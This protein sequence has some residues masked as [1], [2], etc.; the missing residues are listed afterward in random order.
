MGMSPLRDPDVS[1]VVKDAAASFRAYV[2]G[3]S[4]AR[5]SVGALGLAG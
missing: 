3:A 5:L 4:I 2:E 1:G